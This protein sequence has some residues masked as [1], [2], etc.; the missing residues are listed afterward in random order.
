MD[1]GMEGAIGAGLDS[2]L[3][4]VKRMDSGEDM[5]LKSI[6]RELNDS[7]N[8]RKKSEEKKDDY[9][10]QMQLN[11]V[12]QSQSAS[13]SLANESQREFMPMNMNPIKNYNP[14]QVDEEVKNQMKLIDNLDNDSPERQKSMFNVQAHKSILATDDA[15]DYISNNNNATVLKDAVHE[16]HSRNKSSCEQTDNGFN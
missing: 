1:N 7:E 15:N 3:N 5:S 6:E 9:S 11:M 4:I 12:N 8:A 10:M 2:N 16:Q 13:L 14:Q